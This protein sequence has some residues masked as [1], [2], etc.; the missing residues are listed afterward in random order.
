MV[1]ALIRRKHVTIQEKQQSFCNL[2]SHFSVE[3]VIN[4]VINL[5]FGRYIAIIIFLSLI[6]ISLNILAN[7]PLPCFHELLLILVFCQLSTYCTTVR[8]IEAQ[9][10]LNNDDMIGSPNLFALRVKFNSRLTSNII[11]IPT[12]FFGILIPSATFRLINIEIDYIVKAFCFVALS[13]V[14]MSCTIGA[15][16]YLYLLVFIHNIKKNAHRINSGYD[17]VQSHT[18]WI[19]D[20]ISV[21]RT[22]NIFFLLVGTAFILAFCL[23]S[24]SG[25]FGIN[26]EEAISKICLAVFWVVITVCIILSA[27]VATIWSKITIQKTID[28]IFSNSQKNLYEE[29]LITEDIGLK[30]ERGIRL[31]LLS[32]NRSQLIK[33]KAGFLATLISL[34]NIVASVEATVSLINMIVNL[35]IPSILT[36]IELL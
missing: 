25:K 18:K 14:T 21:S 17:A 24:F 16:Y 12:I 13:V 19:N 2:V 8:I 31:S 35:D 28:I 34:I 9:R 36:K 11:Y 4:H 33:Q 26:Y 10:K 23:F 3:N 32:T 20:V 1:I 6:G 5:S 7:N 22:C 30:I 27:I 29:F 15:I